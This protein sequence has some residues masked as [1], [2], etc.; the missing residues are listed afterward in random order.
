M[1]R[2]PN[3]GP[4]PQPLAL[5]C[6]LMVPTS[7]LCPP[8]LLFTLPP[9]AAGDTS[10]PEPGEVTVGQGGDGEAVVTFSNFMD[11]ETTITATR[12]MLGPSNGEGVWLD[13]KLEENPEQWRGAP[14]KPI[15][16]GQRVHACVEATNSDGL[17][18]TACAAEPIYWDA[19]P[20]VVKTWH[21]HTGTVSYEEGRA[22]T[23][24][25]QHVRFEFA[26][27]DPP[28]QGSL[29]VA[30]VQWAISTRPKPQVD[31]SFSMIDAQHSSR[32]AM[33]TGMAEAEALETRFSIEHTLSDEDA[34]VHANDYFLSLYVCDA[35]ANCVMHQSSPVQVDLSPPV[36]PDAS[37]FLAS[38]CAGARV[39]G[40]TSSWA[41]VP[42]TSGDPNV[43]FWTSAEELK[44]S[45]SE[46]S[47]TVSRRAPD[48]L[49]GTV[50]LRNSM[51]DPES[52]PVSVSWRIFEYRGAH[53][54][55]EVRLPGGQ[56]MP[57]AVG[58]DAHV[59][60]H[61]AGLR[62]GAS[63]V[64][65][66]HARNGAGSESTF[67]SRPLAVD[68]TAPECTTPNPSL[69]PASGDLRDAIVYPRAGGSYFA[70]LTWLGPTASGV[71]FVADQTL[72]VDP[73]SGISKVEV[74]IG[75]RPGTSTPSVVPFH[76]VVPP[77]IHSI[78]FTSTLAEGYAHY[79]LMRCT[80]GARASTFCAPPEFMVDNSGPL[81]FPYL[82]KLRGEGFS[83][84]WAQAA[85]TRLTVEYALAMRDDETGFHS[86]EYGLQ[87]SAP[88]LPKPGPA[89][90]KAQG[91][92]PPHEDDVTLLPQANHEGDP[93][94]SLTIYGLELIHGLWYRVLARG[95]N[96]V[97]MPM[98]WCPSYWVQIDAT[99]PTTGRAIILRSSDDALLDAP[100]D[101]AY[102]YRTDHV[103][104]TLRGFED[105]ES[106]LWGFMVSVLG[107]DGWPVAIEQPF[108]GAFFI[109]FPVALQHRQGVRVKVR[110]LNYAGLESVVVSGVV[111]V[112]ATPPVISHVSDFGV[113]GE[114]S[115]LVRG[116]DL[117]WVVL[118]ETYDEESG[119]EDAEVCLGSLPGMCDAIQPMSVD[120]QRRGVSIPASLLD[121]F[122][123]WAT[124]I[125]Y[126]RA[127]ALSMRTSD[128][129]VV[130][131]APP[132]CGQ[133]YDGLA[134]DA[135]W[136]GGG[137]QL[138]AAWA[139]MADSTSGVAGYS[140]AIIPRGTDAASM[141][142]VGLSTVAWVPVPG[143][144]H[145][146]AYSTAVRVRDGVGFTT[147]CLSDGFR[148]DL[149]PP[150]EPTR[151][152]SLV[153][154]RV[155]AVN[156]QRDDDFL[157]LSWAAFDEPESGL[158]EYLI[159]C[160]TEEQPTRYRSF[161]TVGRGLEAL[162]TSLRLPQG[163]VRVTVRAVNQASL[164]TDANVTVHVDRPVVPASPT[165]HVPHADA[166]TADPP[167]VSYTDPQF[168]TLYT[169]VTTGLLGMWNCTDPQPG[170]LHQVEWAVGSVPAGD[171]MMGWTTTQH[172]SGTHSTEDDAGDIGLASGGTYFISV[173]AR[174]WVGH[175]LLVVSPAIRIDRT[176]PVVTR[177]AV[178]V[179]NA[180]GLQIQ[181]LAL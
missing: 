162:I 127:G 71:R 52:G 6:A 177:D 1:D 137:L 140:V 171:D 28:A 99:P 34:L 76:D 160:G 47:H 154:S 74:G 70:S 14:T 111:M 176:P 9:E 181:P 90:G 123:Y 68:D 114:E 23:N 135:M 169:R 2:G 49:M 141:M 62:R 50:D 86:I 110:A 35:M 42:G 108:Y 26:V 30:S 122:T 61:S 10:P 143:L 172:A 64:V 152:E 117:D 153:E 96:R 92:W 130:D 20:P 80:N 38:A 17:S 126:N 131:A 25:S 112:D 29:G 159:A 73:E 79:L 128:G 21:W 78:E 139:N 69:L 166:S 157:W 8:E 36:V 104:L 12:V 175:S 82:A 107:L 13:E 148:V 120:Y 65:Q 163:E 97:G 125:V 124:L 22:H 94:A 67:F 132:M 75:Y 138:S 88:N 87:R 103:Y 11:T 113:G 155:P 15:P 136:V 151:L 150:G 106:G 158:R 39:P 173:L 56:Q 58:E 133:V 44:L 164:A 27:S 7:L 115:D 101:A 156:A 40:C 37:R 63:Y 43:P 81:C 5:C 32:I 31:E 72:C 66:V 85:R 170:R 165:L 54:L 167:L 146:M 4:L 33:L 161:Q 95:H 100:P 93:P 55:I 46:G 48:G 179:S 45:W 168:G 118:W 102:Q 147:D 41:N 19:S 91:A 60:L 84:H 119:V 59:E 18:T 83:P 53:N 129:F 105:G 174:D 3:L 145:N 180:T 121:G 109:S 16:S 142:D 98:E 77:V 134:A 89:R 51:V 57:V 178:L 149:T 116:P 144:A 24:S